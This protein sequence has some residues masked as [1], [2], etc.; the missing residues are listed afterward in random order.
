MR[1][2]K[3]RA[4]STAEEVMVEWESLLK[5]MRRTMDYSMFEDDELILMQYTGLKDKN[6]KEIYEGD[7]IKESNIIFTVK[8]FEEDGAFGFWEKTFVGSKERFFYATD[9]SR[10]E[11]IG[12][13]HET[14]ELLKGKE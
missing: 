14:P 12:N 9:A 11:V 7:I 1:E 6:G 8:Y 3:F 10:Y 13:I 4:W 5:T 2:I